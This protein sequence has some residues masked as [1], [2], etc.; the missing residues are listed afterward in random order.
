MKAAAT[1]VLGNLSLGKDI[2]PSLDA[3][4]ETVFIF[5]TENMAPMVENILLN[6]PELLESGVS[7]ALQGL[8]LIKNN[9]DVFVQNGIELVSQLVVGIVSALP[10]LVEAAVGITAG[11]GS[12]LVN[13]DWIAVATGLLTQLRD[14]LGIAAM[15]ILGADESVVNAFFDS[16]INSI[17]VLAQAIQDTFSSLWNIVSFIWNSVGQPVFDS[18]QRVLGFA[19][20]AFAERMPAIRQFVE[21]C[22][23]D[24]KVFW[25]NNLKPC[26]SAIGDFIKNILAPT[27]ES[28]FQGTIGPTVDTAFKFIEDIWKDTL[29]PVLTGITDFLTGVFTLNFKQAWEGIKSIV[30]GIINGIIS[31]VEGFINSIINALNGLINGINGLVGSAGSV[32]GL[33]VQIPTIPTISLPKMEYGGILKRGQVGL[34]EGNG[35]EAVIPLDQN[36]KWISAVAQDMNAFSGDNELL[37][38][39]LNVLLELK[40]TMPDKLLDALELLRFKLNNREFARLVK[41]VAM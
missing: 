25:D 15:E 1:N 29:K 8:N 2:G 40:E 17:P 10:Y 23:Q 11:L 4:G 33:D 24:I 7:M 21:S 5:L 20:D 30:T 28:I 18:L 13:T 19:Y 35:D 36:Q 14:G 12:A 31:S 22:F 37:L 6:L 16:L 26:F 34:L 41:E 32:I 39:I 38:Q 27:F 3:L 9:A